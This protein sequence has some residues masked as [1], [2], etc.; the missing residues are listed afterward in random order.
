MLIELGA[1]NTYNLRIAWEKGKWKIFGG[2]R[3][4]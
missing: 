2:L 1:I 3:T 4:S